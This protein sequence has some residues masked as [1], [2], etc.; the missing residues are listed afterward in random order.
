[1][2]AY[3]FESNSRT[4]QILREHLKDVQVEYRLEPLNSQNADKFAD[5]E[6]VS[7]FVKS[8]LDKSAIEKLENLK[9]IA[10]RSA[11]YD[12]INIDAIAQTGITVTN[13]P[14][15]GEYTVAEHTIALMLSVS[16]NI[17]ESYMRALKGN[18]KIGELVGF[19]LKGKT[20]GIVGTGSIGLHVINIA[21]GFAMKVLAYSRTK[22]E[23]MAIAMGYEYVDSFEDLLSRVDVLS[24]HVPL[25][26]ATRHMLNSENIY[27]LKKGAVVINTAYNL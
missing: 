17:H 5:A 20:L 21:K 6:I 25:V 15:Y 9:L 10:T 23:E 7:I 4:E 3:I 19:E 13:A 22:K 26:E 18:F 1:M 11:G 14:R 8:T 16:R 12:H 24:F 27:K 2:K